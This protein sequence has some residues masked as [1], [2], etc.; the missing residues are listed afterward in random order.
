MGSDSGI[1]FWGF[2]AA[3][4]LAQTASAFDVVD[5]TPGFNFTIGSIT[6]NYT[7]TLTITNNT[8]VNASNFTV[9]RFFLPYGIVNST[10]CNAT[11]TNG[12][13]YGVNATYSACAVNVTNAGGTPFNV[14]MLVRL[15]ISAFSGAGQVIPRRPSHGDLGPVLTFMNATCAVGCG[16][17][18]VT[19]NAVARYGNHSNVNPRPYFVN[20]TGTYLN[21][22]SVS[23]WNQTDPIYSIQLP[24]MTFNATS[25]RPEYTNDSFGVAMYFDKDG[26]MMMPTFMRLYSY[27]LNFTFLDVAN[28]SN[29][30]LY[31]P[32]NT[33]SETNGATCNMQNGDCPAESMMPL[34]TRT[35]VFF[36]PITQ[37]NTS[38]T[39][40]T[41]SPS[42]YDL[43]VNG[44]IRTINFS[45]ANETGYWGINASFQPGMMQNAQGIFRI[46]VTDAAIAQSTTYGLYFTITNQTDVGG[47]S[48]IPTSPVYIVNQSISGWD[49]TSPPPFGQ[50]LT[51]SYIGWLRNGLKNW[52]FYNA[53]L[54]YFIPTNATP[55]SPT[56]DTD[57]QT[58][59]YDGGGTSTNC[60]INMTRNMNFSWTTQ[61]RSGW[62]TAGVSTNNS[63][64]TFNDD[65]PGEQDGGNVTVCFR[66]YELNIINTTFNSW[67]PNS[68]ATSIVGVN[69]TAD[70]SFPVMDETNVPSGTAGAENSYNIT[71]QTSMQTNLNLTDKVPNI[72]NAGCSGTT[73]TIDGSALTCGTN[74][75]IGSL[76]LNSVSQGSHTISVSYTPSASSG[77]GSSSG[78]GSGG[79]GCG[80]GGCGRSTATPTP[81]PTPTATPP[82]T[83]KKIINSQTGVVATFGSKGAT[84]EL[85][86]EADE[87]GFYGD[88][89]WRLPFDYSQYALG[90]VR[91][92]PQPKRVLKGS[93]IATWENVELSPGEAFKASV[94]VS[95]ELERSILE[96][97]SA[98]S[99]NAKA[100]PTASVETPSSTPAPSRSALQPD[101]TLILVLIAIA[102]VVAYYLG[103]VRKRK[104]L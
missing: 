50:N 55:R 10:A 53:S 103:V 31:N 39:M 21:N 88:L 1:L 30:T 38:F 23:A 77:S 64:L 14:S 91:I 11:G 49:P 22:V 73:I 96:E 16:N 5:A 69:F 94:S 56:N 71:F 68:T 15:N 44:T 100:K 20:Q 76:T 52:T 25:M 85:S 89:T 101:Y 90:L 80:E 18:N 60:T 2:L 62:D 75:T 63:C 82:A 36:D 59:T 66:S 57:F 19:Q 74:Y 40:S 47:G 78:G 7:L 46:N 102:L 6:Q 95:K 65:R 9:V 17:G 41:P 84:F 4:L 58:C 97:F 37:T 27:T 83:E 79:P 45:S 87:N 51:I 24:I 99:L 35:E 42:G 12:L 32:V 13:F 26:Q 48:L 67:N 70:I 29:F 86:Y 98:P 72:A 43:Y 61:G 3:V 104:G 81:V 8:P 34:L 33:S 92:T 28:G 54:R 93:V